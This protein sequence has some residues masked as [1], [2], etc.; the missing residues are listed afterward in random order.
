MGGEITSPGT[1]GESELIVIL[2]ASSMLAALG[3][4]LEVVVVP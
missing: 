3:V 4:A 2:A 1:L